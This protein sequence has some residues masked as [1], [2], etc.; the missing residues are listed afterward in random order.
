MSVR[1]HDVIC[2]DFRALSHNHTN[3]LV[4]EECDST[5]YIHSCKIISSKE[6]LL[7][8]IH[9]VNEKPKLFLFLEIK[10]NALDSDNK[11]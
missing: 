11:L 6:T 5:I 7:L 9:Y 1:S 2:D 10:N 4:V 8:H 3:S